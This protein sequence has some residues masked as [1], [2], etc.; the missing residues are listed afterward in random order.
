MGKKSGAQKG[1]LRE[2]LAP[3]R[4]YR[5]DPQQPWRQGSAPLLELP[6][7]TVLGVPLTGAVLAIAGPPLAGWIGAMAASLGFVQLELHGVDLMDL[8]AD[9]LPVDLSV[10]HD[11]TIPWQRKAEAVVA[12]VRCL[13]RTHRAVTLQEAATF[14][15]EGLK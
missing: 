14:L 13:L 3:N 7:S 1:D 6:V 15:G 5:P 9:G 11:L 10:Q 2:S 12:F 4:P 8:T